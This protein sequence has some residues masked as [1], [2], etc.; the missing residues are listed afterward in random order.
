[1]KTPLVGAILLGIEALAAPTR[2]LD[3]A[4]GGRPIQ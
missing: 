3:G 2:L 1:M 4:F